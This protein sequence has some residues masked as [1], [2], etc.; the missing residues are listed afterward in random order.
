MFLLIS[1]HLF[2]LALRHNTDTL[3]ALALPEKF[4]FL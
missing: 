4:S 1:T 3:F 2:L